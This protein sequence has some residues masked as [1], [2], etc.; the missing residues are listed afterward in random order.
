MGAFRIL[1]THTWVHN[2]NAIRFEMTSIAPDK[3]PRIVRHSY[4]TP[5]IYMH[6]TWNNKL[7]T[8]Y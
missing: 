1:Q 7:K 4:I 8:E 2:S 3:K 6:H 5:Y